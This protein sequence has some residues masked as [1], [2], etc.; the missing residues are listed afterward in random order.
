MEKQS[1]YFVSDMHFGIPDR[2]SSGKREHLFI[3]WLEG[4][5]KD[6]SDIYFMGDMFDFWFE[7]KR[8][9]PKGYIRLL[10]K[11]AELSDKG[12]QLHFF[13][14]NH[15]MWMFSYFEKEL[16]ATIYRNDFISNLQGKTLYLS[17]GDGKGPG[18]YG[19]KFIKSIFRNRFAQWCY[20]RLHPNFAIGLADFLSR[21]SRYSNQ[22]KNSKNNERER[23][24]TINQM[25]FSR[26]ILK[27]MEVDYF[28]FG[29]QHTPVIEKIDDQ[30]ILFNIGNWITDYSYLRLQEGVITQ[31]FFQKE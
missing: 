30:S 28:I 31:L 4:I 6:A 15:D 11:L 18:D 2:T 8:V 3:E 16:N 10:G 13:I 9:I 26:K 21:K 5:S 7:W 1:I 25:I 29:H 23:K 12:I 20:A 27:N 17:H 24:L 22:I 14:G 19:Y